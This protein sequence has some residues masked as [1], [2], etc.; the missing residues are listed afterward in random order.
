M[1]NLY[2]LFI[3]LAFLA[4]VLF[5]EGAYLAWNSYRG[6][7]AKRMEKRLRAMSAGG[8]VKGSSLLKQRMLA[9][10]PRGH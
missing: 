3:V 6:P 7:E 10:F 8:D 2:Y 1:N 5:L 9:Q 4:V